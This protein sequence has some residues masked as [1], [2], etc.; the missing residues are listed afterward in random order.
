MESVLAQNE[1]RNKKNETIHLGLFILAVVALFY[2]SELARLCA[3]MFNKIYYGDLNDLFVNIIRGLLYL[4]IAIG[5][6]EY[7]KRHFRLNFIRDSKERIPLK[8]VAILY[9]IVVVVIFLITASL[10]FK[11]KIVVDLGENIIGAQLV[12]RIVE[13]VVGIIRMSIVVILI[14]HFQ[15]LIERLVYKNWVRYVPFGGLFAMI[16]IG[17]FVFCTSP[18]SAISV[19]LLLMYLVYGEIYLLSYRL[20]PTTFVSCFLIQL[21]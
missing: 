18:F 4:A 11:V 3:P 21:L 8:R 1:Q 13:I 12:I 16:A 14:R 2:C 5:A 20:F 7:S 15:E 9:S 17:I 10:G 6:F 19:V